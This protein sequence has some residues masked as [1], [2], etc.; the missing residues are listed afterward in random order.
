MSEISAIVTRSENGTVWIKSLQNNACGGCMQQAACGTGALAKLLPNREYPVEGAFDVQIGDRVCV[1]VAESTVL[2][3][4]LLLYLVPLLVVFAGVGLA[5]AVMPAALADDWL[6]EIALAL[7]LL[8]F[9]GIQRMQ[10][11]L[12]RLFSSKPTIT[13]KV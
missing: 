7:L 5:S 4:S 2:F 1:T 3:S 8:A 12:L 13:K 9:G 10:T 11:R 6:P